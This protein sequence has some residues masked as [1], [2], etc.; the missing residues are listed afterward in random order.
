[1]AKRVRK[2]VLKV[3]SRVSHVSDPYLYE[4]VIV[5]KFGPSNISTKAGKCWSVHWSN[6]KRGSYSSNDIKKLKTKAQLP[7]ETTKDDE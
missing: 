4:G 6:G 2:E 7:P 5:H 3:G 1:M